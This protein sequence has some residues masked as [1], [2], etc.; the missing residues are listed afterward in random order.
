MNNSS[1]LCG[2]EHMW[3]YAGDPKYF[4]YEGMPCACGMMQWHTEI[5]PTCG[6]GVV[7]PINI[8][9]YSITVAGYIL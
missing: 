4:P 6:Q 7:K 2:S 9:E 8:N 5:C 1:S 3:V